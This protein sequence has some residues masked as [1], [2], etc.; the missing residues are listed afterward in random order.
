MTAKFDPNVLVSRYAKSPISRKLENA[1]IS[2][3]LLFVFK[4]VYP[5]ISPSPLLAI[6][7]SLVFITFF[8]WG[9]YISDIIK[10]SGLTPLNLVINSVALASAL[11]FF[12]TIFSGYFV[13]LKIADN[14]FNI[15]NWLLYSFVNGLFF[16]IGLILFITLRELSF[17][18]QKK[19]PSYY[20]NT[21]VY[22]LFFIFAIRAAIALK[23]DLLPLMN[24][25]YVVVII[26][27][28]INSIRVAWIAFLAKK[29]KLIL[30]FLSVFLSVIF[31]LNFSQ[32]SDSHAGANVFLNAFSPGGALLLNLTMLYGTIYFGVVFFTTLFHLPT[33]EAF[34]RK[35]EEVETLTNFTNLM[36]RV[37]DFDEL[38]ENLTVQ[39][40]KLSKADASWL[41]VRHKEGF[42]I[43]AADM[44]EKSDAIAITRQIF[45]SERE[46]TEMK[47]LENVNFK[48]EN[49]KAVRTFSF[50]SLILA[51]LKIQG[52]ISGYLFA[53]SFGSSSFDSDDFGTIRAFADYAAVALEN[54]LLIRRSIEKER[55]EKELDIA[56]EIQHKIIPA[57]PPAVK[58]L[59]IAASFIP[60]F[61]AGGDY[62]D[63]FPLGDN[64][65]AFVIADVS[66]KGISAAFVMAELKGIFESLVSFAPYPKE[67]LSKTNSLLTK[68]LGNKEFVTAIYGIMDVEKGVVKLA[69]AG[70]SPA[71]IIR[72]GNVIRLL[73]K[74]IGL[75]LDADKVFRES[76]E[77]EEF[78]LENNDLIVFYTDGVT[79]SMNSRNEFFGE[80]RLIASLQ[81]NYSKSP[82][83]I[84]NMILTEISLFSKNV[85]QH[86]DITL[87][88]FK[89]KIKNKNKGKT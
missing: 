34:D 87:V 77:E 48:V 11:Y 51:P 5:K 57:K 3:I 29:E 14:G 55:L 59:Q 49:G 61:E 2:A 47:L 30:L 66:G 38:A 8:F 18:R 84:L 41:I 74:G 42:E 1:V 28:A 68:S 10:R 56:R 64:K 89:W 4:I 76:L 63:F 71:L 67:I 16:A 6:N 15:F 50:G 73:P 58:N 35:S 7:E 60:A 85:V 37:L 27:F 25:V 52:K 45:S 82:E 46:S 54:S 69:R 17:L 86:D 33:A 78:E 53:G 23:I 22:F 81:E 44:V 43:K 20:F 80:K 65:F 31:A 70:H 21:M 72:K 26:L 79:E 40:R 88:I 39:V 36:T 13:S 19:F 32:T 75:S 9:F 62:Y 12:I 83:E 24:A